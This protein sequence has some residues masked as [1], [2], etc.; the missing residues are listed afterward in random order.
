VPEFIHNPVLVA[1]VLAALRPRPGGRYVDGTVGG[2]G[3]AAAILAAS[4]PSGW[5]FGCDRD[6]VAVEAATRRLAEFAGRFE[7][8]RGNFSD[9]VEW[10]E[11]E[12]CDGVL[13]D[14]GVSSAQLDQ[15]GR[16]FSFQQHGPLDM[17]MDLGQSLTA[18]DVVN[19]S[20]AEEL[21]WI[22]RELGE[23]PHGRQFARAIVQ[24]RQAR[25]F[26]T[27]GQLAGLIERLAPRYGKKRHPAT[28]VFQALRMRVNDERRSLQSG[29][30][31]A[32]SRL[33]PG[34]RLAI[35]TFHS[36]EDRLVKAFGRKQT[37]DYT[38]EG[39]VD[40]PELRKP[41]APKMAWVQ[42]KAVCPGPAEL[43]SNP[44]ARSAQLRVL[45]KV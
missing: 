21:V 3:H 41:C 35:I 32:L 4:S 12:S 38:F 13:L 7:I 44:R 29:L 6:G 31:A 34:G 17:R 18:A 43:A 27:T 39:D 23:E 1:E 2:G 15:A 28:R 30:A 26:E 33:K 45:E 8:R 40:I 19:E 20:S 5:L 42:R 25:R 11:P 14:L 24:E 36:G 10:V 9:L 37:R 22:F 16:G